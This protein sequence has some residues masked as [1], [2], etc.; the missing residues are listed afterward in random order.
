MPV[1]R[2]VQRPSTL[3][4]FA[5]MLLLNTCV[6][7]HAV[8]IQRQNT[9]HD[10]IPT[11]RIGQTGETTGQPAATAR[12]P[13]ATPGTP[14]ATAGSTTTGI[15][16]WG[17]LDGHAAA[18][19]PLSARRIGVP[20][21]WRQHHIFNGNAG[22]GDPCPVQWPSH[23]R[24]W[25]ASL[26]RASAAKVG[27]TL[28]FTLPA[29]HEIW[30]HQ[31]PAD[32]ASAK[33]IVYKG[34]HSGIGSVF[35]VQSNILKLALD[36]GRVLV[37][38]PGHFLTNHAYCGSNT[39]LD[40]C[41]FEPL[42]N[43]S[44]GPTDIA[45]AAMI[46]TMD[47]HKL[48]A[49]DP[50]MPRVVT[51]DA[52]MSFKLRLHAPRVFETWLNTTL[53]PYSE[54]FYWWRAQASAYIVRPNTRVLA[55]LAAR[56]QRQLRGGEL[57][58]GCVSLYVRHG[59]KGTESPV[60]TDE[61]YEMA[62]TKLRRLDPSLTHQVFLSTEDPKTVAY[63]SDTTRGWAT[64]Y[65]D[66]PR[67]P[68]RHKSNMQYMQEHGVAEEMLDGLLNLHLACECDGYV[69]SIFSNWA[70]LIDEMRST[71]RCKEECLYMDVHYQSAAGVDHNW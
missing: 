18:L 47:A 43:C 14:Q 61:Q 7:Y 5:A 21:A 62:T 2:C 53:I 66:M 48:M 41:Y 46:A 42:T 10:I 26:S 65:V 35:H 11:A 8:F 22:L 45:N 1:T 36:S 28:P 31:H 32:C 6:L 67:K 54:H 25:E 23:L 49:R 12:T 38:Q 4:L 68:D 60:F 16:S 15:G 3:V 63:F 37:E 20:P 39:T 52:G 57:R 51:V 27:S 59:D 30:A 19:S 70:R 24:L 29:Q 40:S 69:S 71:V 34:P 17:T 44:L 64:S 13:E 50:A 55:E 58:I 33:F 9:R 56:R